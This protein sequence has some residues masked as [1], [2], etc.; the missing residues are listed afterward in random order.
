VVG[1]QGGE[2]TETAKGPSLVLEGGRQDVLRRG[3]TLG[4]P[5]L[6]AL[7]GKQELVAMALGLAAESAAVVGQYRTD[8]DAPDAR[9]KAGTRSCRRSQAVIGIFDV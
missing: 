7:D 9:R 4:R 8:G 1:A 2:L 3:V 5:V 6:D